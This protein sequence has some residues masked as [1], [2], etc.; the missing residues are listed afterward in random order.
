MFVGDLAYAGQPDKVTTTFDAH[1][2]ATKTLF[3]RIKSMNE[4]VNDCI[5]QAF[6]VAKGS[7]RHGHGTEDKL[8]KIKLAFEASAILVQYDIEIVVDVYRQI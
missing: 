4:T 6:K 7:F 2:K 8:A 5:K 1:S 3:A